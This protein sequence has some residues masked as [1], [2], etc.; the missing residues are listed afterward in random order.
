MATSLKDLIPYFFDRDVNDEGEQEDLAEYIENLNFAVDGQKYT[1]ESRQLIATR[2]IFR[3][4]LRDKALFWYHSL[5]PETRASWQ[6]LETAF[7]SRFALVVQKEMDQTRFLNLIFNFKQR[8]RSI[9][10]YTR[11]GDQ[12]NAECPENFQDVLGHQFIAG[13]DDKG[14]VD[15][16]QVYLGAGKLSVKYTEAKQAVE[17]AYQRFGEPSPFDTLHSCKKQDGMV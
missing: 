4:H 2:V 16:V 1:D 12:L 3:T 11:E 14:K 10:E 7:L 8:G 5:S 15:L 13:L 9:V 17:K 6:L